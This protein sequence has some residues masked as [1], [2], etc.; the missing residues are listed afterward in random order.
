MKKIL[1][2][3]NPFS[4]KGRSPYFAAKLKKQFAKFGETDVYVFLSESIPA[5]HDFFADIAQNK[6]LFDAAVFLGG[7]GTFGIAV[8]AMIKSGLNFPVA[9]FPLGTVNDFAKQLKMKAN[10]KKCVDVILKNKTRNSDIALVNGDFVVNVAC[11]GYFTHGANTYNRTA[12]KIFGR[13]AYYGKG[14]FSA[15]NMHAQKLKISVDDNKVFSEKVLMYLILNSKSAGGF[16]KIGAEA[17]IDD[18]LFDLCV[19]K[20]AGLFSLARTFFR[21]LC[22]KHAK[23]KNVIYVKGKKFLVELEGKPNPKFLK[24]DID[25]NVGP[26]LPLAVEVI[27]QKL[28]VF[29]VN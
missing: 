10:V 20:K 8:D 23:D 1:I 2:V 11:G 4:G 26:S 6:T 29:S 19:I 13:L 3:A 12:K 14:A 15:F 16:K 25:G 27:A 24:S 5:L 28:V 17:E 7:D 21:I 22:G 9:I 18:G